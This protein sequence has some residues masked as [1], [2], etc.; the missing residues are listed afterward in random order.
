MIERALIIAY[1]GDLHAEAVQWALQK[2]GVQCDTFSTDDFPSDGRMNIS[3]GEEDTPHIRFKS[4][5]GP[6]KEFKNYQ[7]IWL[8][9]VAKFNDH[10][11]LDPLDYEYSQNECKFFIESLLAV[12]NVDSFWVNPP[13]GRVE[14]GKKGLQ[15]ILAKEL[16]LRIPKTI[17]G[18]DPDEVRRLYEASGGSLIFKPFRTRGWLDASTNT[19]YTSY[20]SLVTQ[21]ML[22]SPAIIEAAPGIYQEKIIK[23]Y[24][25]RA[26]FFGRSY[27]A[28]RIDSQQREITQLDWRRE[29]QAIETSELL[30]PDDI[31]EK[32][33]QLM[34]SLGIV[35]GSFDF[36]VDADD[37]FFYLEVNESGSFLLLETWQPHLRVLDGFCEFLISG[38]KEFVYKKSSQPITLEEFED[39]AAMQTLIATQDGERFKRQVSLDVQEATT[40]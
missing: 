18:N 6:V 40:K 23:K 10:P 5:A 21:D 31:Y 19:N 30:L 8:R 35:T 24:E 20:T 15:L 11:L 26:F 7:S 38:D 13:G 36:I 29:Q 14:S 34:E 4:G 28:C 2:K 39:S 22:D 27:F 33:L 16:G 12:G 25:V 32:C 37:N 3:I 1:P 9:R 17:M